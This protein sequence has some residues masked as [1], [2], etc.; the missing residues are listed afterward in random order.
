MAWRKNHEATFRE[1]TVLFT[2]TLDVGESLNIERAARRLLESDIAYSAAWPS[3]SSV[4][5]PSSSRSLHQLIWRTQQIFSDTEV[6][7]KGKRWWWF[8][9]RHPIIVLRGFRSVRAHSEEAS[10]EAAD[11]HSPDSGQAAL[12]KAHEIVM[13]RVKVSAA[14]R[15]IDAGLFSARSRKSDS[16]VRLVLRNSYH[17]VKGPDAEEIYF[18]AEPRLLLHRSG[19]VQLTIAVPIPRELRTRDLVRL[20]HASQ[21]TAIRSEWSEP[22]LADLPSRHLGGEWSSDLDSNARLR[23]ITYDGGNE[24]SAIML[25]YVDACF[26]SIGS[27][28]RTG[29]LS[30]PTVMTKAGDCC[31]NSRLWRKRH[32]E[33]IIR[34]AVRFD[35]R[36]E[37][38]PSASAGQ[39]LAVQR[40]NSLYVNM[41]SATHIT[42]TGAVADGISQL[43]TVLIT[44][45][46]V[47]L[48]WR[49]RQMDRAL[50]RSDL[51]GR[52]VTRLNR[53]SLKLL[54]E[55]RLEDLSHGTTRHI[56]RT[57][58]QDL[59]GDQ[60]RESLLTSLDLTSQ[61]LAMREGA[62][63]SRRGAWLA[64]LAVVFSL[65]VA[66]PTLVGPL[67]EWGGGPKELSP[68]WLRWVYSNASELPFM[69]LGLLILGG[70]LALIV[71]GVVRAVR[72]SDWP[73]QW[74]RR[75]YY[76]K[77]LRLEARP[78][79]TEEN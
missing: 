62:S 65:V 27:R 71:G 28:S 45:Y 39:D 70:V 37:L 64:F 13:N 17:W 8:S 26:A 30:Y 67:A 57:A 76:W 21:L 75:G 69:L 22:L 24:W 31:Q 16:F 7:T 79:D 18:V 55:A 49:L 56:V 41:G 51:R 6:A 47:L 20:S 3:E 38:A 50:A 29:W 19:A 1:S 53:A 43:Y 72:A 44:E 2:F 77:R 23:T 54:A 34:L 61:A 32:A 35:S 14:E 59:G 42:F 46:A 73:H 40:D 52:S 60:V 66:I 11:G 63:Q 15:S 25:R 48:Y 10:E 33:D 74:R 12:D 78:N 4:R 9:L 5:V 36:A 68:P 58:L